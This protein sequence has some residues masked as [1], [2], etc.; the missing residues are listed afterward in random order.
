MKC[1]P[2]AAA[3]PQPRRQKAVS[4]RLNWVGKR[5][6]PAPA[7]HRPLDHTKALRPWA[8]GDFSSPGRHLVLVDEAW[9]QAS[10]GRNSKKKTGPRQ[11]HWSKKGHAEHRHFRATAEEVALRLAHVAVETETK[12]EGQSRLQRASPCGFKKAAPALTGLRPV[13]PCFP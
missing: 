11:H 10:R 2:D 4:N 8:C 5:T 9:T 1:Q 6:L 3:L 13:A 7:R 12:R